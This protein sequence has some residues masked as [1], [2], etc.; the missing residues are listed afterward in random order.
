MPR[1]S[2]R[3]LFFSGAVITV[4]SDSLGHSFSVISLFLYRRSKKKKKGKVHPWTGTE[5]LYRPYG[6]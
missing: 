3:S 2:K 5:A 6:P 4:L 1:S